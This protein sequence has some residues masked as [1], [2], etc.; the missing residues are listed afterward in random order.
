MR[1]RERER[2]NESGPRE[3]ERER[4]RL[5][6]RGRSYHRQPFR[7]S[8]GSSRSTFREIRCALIIHSVVDFVDGFPLLLLA[9]CALSLEFVVAIIIDLARWIWKGGPRSPIKGTCCKVGDGRWKGNNYD[10]CREF[11][12]RVRAQFHVPFAINDSRSCVCASRVETK[13]RAQ[14]R[15]RPRRERGREIRLLGGVR[16]KGEAEKLVA[17]ES[18]RVGPLAG[19]VRGAPRRCQPAGAL[20]QDRTESG[21]TIALISTR[22]PCRGPPRCNGARR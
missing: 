6:S 13:G 14:G 18:R 11:V 3:R 1:P 12:S 16:T 8:R 7:S 20:F 2:R 19:F 9:C 15:K 17:R 10:N 22:M 5:W 4:E 21:T